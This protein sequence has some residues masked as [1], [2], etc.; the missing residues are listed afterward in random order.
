[1]VNCENEIGPVLGRTEPG[2][3]LSWEDYAILYWT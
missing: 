2:D 1:M 3:W